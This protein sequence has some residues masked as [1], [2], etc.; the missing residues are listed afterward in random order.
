MKTVI[1]TQEPTQKYKVTLAAFCQISNGV[2]TETN[3]GWSQYSI[4]LPSFVDRLSMQIAVIK[5]ICQCNK[6][7][8]IEAKS[9]EQDFQ[10]IR[11]IL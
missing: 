2:L 7:F 5:Q 3:S 10:I 4:N 8:T 1:Q 9:G 6:S 11:L